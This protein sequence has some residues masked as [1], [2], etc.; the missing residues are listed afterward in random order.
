MKVLV[1][2]KA[3]L[4]DVLRTTALLPA[5]R[6]A[7][8][9]P[10]WW[11]TA[12]AA[13]PL[14][15]RHPDVARALASGAR[16]PRAFDL[17]LSLEEDLSCARWAARAVKPGG[18]LVGV[19]ERGGRLA[20][21]DDAEPYYGMSLL[22]P[23]QAGGLEKANELK[24]A[25]AR[26]YARLWLSILGL[27]QP[28]T[29]LSPRLFLSSADRAA[30]R[31]LA[32]ENGWNAG[33]PVG[34]NAGAGG[35][36]PS[37]QLSVPAAIAL[38]RGLSSLGRPLLLLGGEEEKDRNARILAAL[39]AGRAAAHPPVSLRAFAGLVELCGAVVATD[40]LAAHVA[41]GV[42]R[43]VVVL[44]GPTSATELDIGARGAVLTPP[45]GCGCFYRAS[46]LRPVH[47]LCEI[48]PERV[49]LEVASF[50]R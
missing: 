33:E 39:P 45:H 48:A 24:S 28:K 44:V 30:A 38:A 34:L 50:L 5:L 18:R 14:L 41:A 17:V 21:T 27:P 32:R 10:V 49:A 40:S 31:A 2:K 11:V 22:R 6:R 13:L 4:G 29:A 12:P 25:N 15:R 1:L 9:S 20:Y 42:G 19:V 26:T 3:A 46:C 16:L 37:K 36:W 8:A 47:C 35:R 7:G 43:P 23:A